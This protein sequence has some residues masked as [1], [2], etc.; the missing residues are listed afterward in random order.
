[1]NRNTKARVEDLRYVQMVMDGIQKEKKQVSS[2]KVPISEYIFKKMNGKFSHLII[3]EF[4]EYQAN[5]S[6]RTQSVSQL[7][8]SVPKVVT[9]TGTMMNG[10]A[11][12]IFFNIFMLFPQ[13][14]LK[15]G[16]S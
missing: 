1:K 8:S 4:H 3:D 14:M 10:Y 5:R 2:Y 11:K 12:S 9:G 7:I 6:S 16:F 15:A 13:K